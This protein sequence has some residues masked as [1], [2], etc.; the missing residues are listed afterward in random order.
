MHKIVTLLVSALMICSTAF[1]KEDKKAKENKKTTY[2]FSGLSYLPSIVKGQGHGIRLSDNGNSKLHLMFDL[3][4]GYNSNPYTLPKEK[5]PGGDMIVQAKPGMQFSYNGS[6][7]QFNLSGFA[8]VAFL[9][10]VSSIEQYKSED[11]YRFW[12]VPN[13]SAQMRLAL[14]PGA[15]FAFA[16]SDVVS[17]KRTRTQLFIGKYNR[18]NNKLNTSLGFRPGGGALMLSGDY[19]F[20]IEHWLDNVD[21]NPAQSSDFEEHMGRFSASWQATGKTSIGAFAKYG[22]YTLTKL[23]KDND[24]KNFW[25]LSVGANL[26]SKLSK[27]FS[28]TLG[29]S[30]YDVNS[31]NK[32]DKLNKVEYTPVNG[33]ASATWLF[34]AKGKLNLR[35]SRTGSPLQDYVVS[36]NNRI[37]ANLGLRFFRKVNLNLKPSISFAEYGKL[38]NK[39]N[40][41]DI[42]VDLDALLTYNI[43]DWISIGYDHQ[44]DFKWSTQPLANETTIKKAGEYNEYYRKYQGLFVVSINY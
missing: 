18:V 9:P 22:K 34:G 36:T 25:P 8:D 15:R 4:L 33:Y 37:N 24:F 12:L 30:Y 11:K 41:S 32:D 39:E 16:I 35:F 14:T 40:R 10:N 1:A 29:A 7:L 44:M 6:K 26:N 31:Y 2:N 13:A 17:W 43:R 3:G 23:T 20:T 38:E 28:I 42:T 27:K 19:N 21:N 5:N